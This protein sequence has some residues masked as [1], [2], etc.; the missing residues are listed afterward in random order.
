MCDQQL[1][2]AIHPF[3]HL[4][5]GTFQSVAIDSVPNL[6]AFNSVPSVADLDTIDALAAFTTLDAFDEFDGTRGW[7]C[8]YGRT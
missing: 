4:F 3:T 2:N 7:E 8:R 6:D 5:S 1:R